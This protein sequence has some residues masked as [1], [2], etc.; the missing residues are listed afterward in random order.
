LGLKGGHLGVDM[1]QLGYFVVVTA[2]F[3]LCPLVETVIRLQKTA[4]LVL[5]VQK[6][7]LDELLVLETLVLNRSCLEVHGLFKDVVEDVGL[8]FGAP[9]LSFFLVGLEKLL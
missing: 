2:T 6:L 1:F 5:E 7:I 8:F 9:E 3:G 4:L